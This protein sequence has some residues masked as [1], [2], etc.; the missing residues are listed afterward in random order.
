MAESLCA[1]Y[2]VGLESTSGDLD[3][4]SRSR[5]VDS[6]ENMLGLYP[7]HHCVQN[8]DPLRSHRITGSGEHLTRHV[9]H[10]CCAVPTEF[11]GG[12]VLGSGR[13][14]LG[15]THKLLAL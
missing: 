8:P 10:F 14:I 15:M 5:E 1:P 4:G 2:E 7:I 9:S 13:D 11:C 12:K 3:F 6:F